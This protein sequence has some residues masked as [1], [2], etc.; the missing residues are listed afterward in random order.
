MQRTA[1][2]NSLGSSN[3][4]PVEVKVENA[5]SL[6]DFDADPEPPIAGAVPQAQQTFVTQATAH[7]AT[8]TNDNNWASF[9][10]APEAKVSHAPSNVNT[11]ESVL[12]QLSVSAPVPGHAFGNPSG[13]GSFRT[14]TTGNITMLPITGDSAVAPVGNRP[15]LPF[16]AG[17]PVAAPI[18]S[19]SAFPPGGAPAI[20]P[21]LTP[22]LPVNGGSSLLQAPGFGQ[23][24]NM[25]YQQPSF[26]PA[27]GSQSTAQQFSP[28]VDVASSNQV[29]L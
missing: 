15:V 26:F 10:V 13:A 12:S 21:G 16:M 6:I 24:P 5:G 11:L 19:V 1:S 17:A 2:S 28:S 4:N 9:D 20:A 7:P 23:G 22:I 8:S 29:G 18:S 25:Q 27:T 3:G 14:A